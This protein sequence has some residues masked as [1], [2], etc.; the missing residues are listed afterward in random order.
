[1]DNYGFSGLKAPPEGAGEADSNGGVGRAS[2]RDGKAKEGHTCR[3]A[4]GLLTFQLKISNLMVF[5]Q[6]H[7]CR[8]ALVPPSRNLVFKPVA[9]AGASRDGESH[10]QLG[11][12]PIGHA[13]II[14][15]VDSRDKAGK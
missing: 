3:H 6:R 5:Q 1:M 9:S 11:F 7:D 15:P 12:N 13:A 4:P 14:L 10:R 2:I 8:H